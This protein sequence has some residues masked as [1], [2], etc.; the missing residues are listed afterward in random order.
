MTA[1]SA[2]ELKKLEKQAA[3]SSQARNLI[4]KRTNLLFNLLLI[5]ACLLTVF[6]LWIIIV[7]SFTLKVGKWILR[8]IYWFRCQCLCEV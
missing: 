6:P 2:R 8:K 1:I 3:K 5:I 4:S 7:S